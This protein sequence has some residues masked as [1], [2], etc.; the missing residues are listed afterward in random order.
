[1]NCE[2]IKRRMTELGYT[3]MK[4]ASELGIHQATLSQKMAGKRPVRL[5]EAERMATILQIPDT[6]FAEYFFT[7]EIA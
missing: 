4:L 7:C 3:Q 5:H 1:M 2:K 6:L